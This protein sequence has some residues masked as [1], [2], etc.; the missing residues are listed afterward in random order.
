MAP[1]AA[2]KKTD[3]AAFFGLPRLWL[4]AGGLIL[5]VGIAL[6]VGLSMLLVRLHLGIWSLPLW[7]FAMAAITWRLSRTAA[8]RGCLREI[9]LGGS[10]E[11]FEPRTQVII[12]VAVLILML[13][14]AMLVSYG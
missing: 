1:T 7:G 10:F 12:S 6:L 9:G 4:Y 11:K 3:S 5:L 8:G 2:E 14:V 13:G